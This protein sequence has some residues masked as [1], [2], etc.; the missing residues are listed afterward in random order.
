MNI[1][2]EFIP[3]IL[4]FLYVSF[5]TPFIIISHSILGKILAMTIIIYYTAEDQV[6]GLLA[7]LMILFYYNLE[8]VEQLNTLYYDKLYEGLSLIEYSYDNTSH[9]NIPTNLSTP[10][11]IANITYPKNIEILDLAPKPII[12]PFDADCYFK[13]IANPNKKREF[14]QTRC[15]HGQL[16]NLGVNVKPENAD[17]IYP[18]IIFYNKKC[19]V[20]DNSCIFSIMDTDRLNTE[21]LLTKPHDSNDWFDI[22][23]NNI[24]KLF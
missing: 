22:V 17:Q 21:E 16:T 2:I 14:T 10:S 19:N 1:L 13:T 23:W 7:C 20:C 18:E 8:Y 4:I 12:E 9:L 3:I 11:S 6:Y 24:S 5:T 15:K